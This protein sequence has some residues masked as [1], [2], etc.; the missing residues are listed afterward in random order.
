VKTN[1]KH[2]ADF[3]FNG[4]ILKANLIIKLNLKILG[5]CWKSVYVYSKD[6][7]FAKVAAPS[8]RVQLRKQTISATVDTLMSKDRIAP[9]FYSYMQLWPK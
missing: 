9:L 5:Q 4:K 7:K 6:T 8:Q 2:K 3:Y 1:N